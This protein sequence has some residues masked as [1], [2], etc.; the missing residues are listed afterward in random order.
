MKRRDFLNTLAASATAAVVPAPFMSSL[1]QAQSKSKMIF[2][3]PSGYSLAFAPVLYAA[4]GGFFAKEGLEVQVEAGRGA[5][6]VV[7]LV[8]AKQAQAGRTGGANYMI[9]RVNNNAPVV[10]FATIAQRSPFAV[11]SSKNA[12]IN[13]PED[14]IGKT[15]G[16]QSAGGSMEATLDLMLMRAGIAGDKLRRERVADSAASF[17]LIESKRVDGFL[18]NTSSAIRLSAQNYPVNTFKLDD[19]VPGQ[20]YVAEESLLATNPAPYVLFTR[21]VSKAVRELLSMSDADLAKAIATMA[22]KFDIP[23]ANNTAVALADLRGNMDLWTTKDPKKILR[24]DEAH[25]KE[26]E[27]LLRKAELL[28]APVSK[29]L[30]TNSVWESALG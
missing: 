18:G 2:L 29:P 16:M 4:A 21:A 6:Q 10:A 7:Q 30:F 28:K 25:W 26:A 3:T 13:K 17:G 8:A 1:V 24:C 22:G 20:V 15:I 11:I 9:A 14:L 27:S 19:G 5:A 12:P 23:G